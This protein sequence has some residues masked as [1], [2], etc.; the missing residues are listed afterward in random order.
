MCIDIVEIWF[1]IVN[2]QIPLIILTVICPRQDN[3]EVLS[4]HVFI[5]LASALSLIFSFP[6]SCDEKPDSLVL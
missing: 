6:V 2:G 4:F 3:G 5:H 1:G